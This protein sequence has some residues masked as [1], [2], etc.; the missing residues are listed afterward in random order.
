VREFL[1][2]DFVVPICEAERRSNQ[3]FV[4]RLFGTAF[5]I[6]DEGIYL[7]AAH[8]LQRINTAPSKTCGLVVK[9]AED[10]ALSRFVPLESQ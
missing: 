8:V 10:P 3:A 5:F 9:D 2:E 7:T 4:K 6:S 1:L